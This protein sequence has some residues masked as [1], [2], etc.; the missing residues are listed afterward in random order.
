MALIENMGKEK[1]GSNAMFFFL[2]LSN[3][4]T[5]SKLKRKGG[6]FC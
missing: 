4:S 3:A 5:A 6:H 2:R 1:I